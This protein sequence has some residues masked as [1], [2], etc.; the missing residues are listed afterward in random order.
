MIR[1]EL[2]RMT[3]QLPYII[4]HLLLYRQMT[5]NYYLQCILDLTIVPITEQ[6]TDPMTKPHTPSQEITTMIPITISTGMYYQ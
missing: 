4:V 1:P 3:R 6:P 5:C 2:F